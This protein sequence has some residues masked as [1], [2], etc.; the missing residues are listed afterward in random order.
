MLKRKPLSLVLFVLAAVP[1]LGSVLA[2]EAQDGNH[3]AS[4]WV[5][6]GT[7]DSLASEF[8]MS[9]AREVVEREIEALSQRSPGSTVFGLGNPA[10]LEAATIGEPYFYFWAGNEFSEFETSETNS[11]V[12]FARGFT[13]RFPVILDGAPLGTLNVTVDAQTGDYRV[14]TRTDGDR[15]YQ[16]VVKV[17]EHF[18]S[19]DGWRVDVV[20][21]GIAGRYFRLVGSSGDV[22]LSPASK[23][24]AHLLGLD[25]EEDNDLR[26]RPRREAEAGI[27][28]ELHKMRELRTRSIEPG[29]QH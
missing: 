26:F 23:D 21:T 18:P 6:R 4:K 15:M 14:L 1:A 28:A 10:K 27:R 19:S 7:V 8:N 22:Q 3:N 17:R 16:R 12:D 5:G 9:R 13:V 20:Q 25:A 2:S 11:L 24:A 29:S